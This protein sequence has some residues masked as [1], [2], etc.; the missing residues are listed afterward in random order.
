MSPFLVNKSSIMQRCLLPAIQVNDK[1]KKILKS[2]G[3]KYGLN[4]IYTV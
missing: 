2:H 4:S 3:A 1:R